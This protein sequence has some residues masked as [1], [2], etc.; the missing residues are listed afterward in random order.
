VE[1]VGPFEGG[2]LFQKMVTLQV[3]NA[4]IAFTSFVFAAVVTER[5]RAGLAVRRAA[6]EL[7]ERVRDRTSELSTAKEQ[8]RR[9]AALLA[10]AQQIAHIGSWEWDI[11]ADVV[12]WSDELFR[13]FGRPPR[14]FEATYDGY[15]RLIHPEDRHGAHA[16]VQRALRE[17][18]PFE[19]DYRVIRPDGEERTVRGRGAVIMDASGAPIR[20]VGTGQDI[21]DQRRAEDVLRRF[22]ANASHEL[23]T[24]LTTVSG[25][26]EAL[27]KRGRDLPPE[28]FD[29][30]LDTLG[31]QGERVRHLL[32]S[33]LDLSRAE[34]GHGVDHPEP[35]G[36]AEATRRVM[37][38]L[39]SPDGTSVDV[40][41]PEDM[42]VM[43]D[44]EALERVLINLLTNAYKYGG[45][46][47]RIEARRD[48]GRSRIVVADDGP[49]V[50]GETIPHLFEPFSR[51]AEAQGTGAGLGLAIA[52]GLVEALGGEIHYEPGVP[53]GARFV[54]TLPLEEA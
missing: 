17:R 29:E 5:R 16:V 12:T 21:T 36:L 40:R 24:P 49:G 2:T 46:H 47:I 7:E 33:L 26:A 39:S 43:V 13:I 19:V 44:S 53:V 22:I 41:V 20:M 34:Q 27:A 45:P 8:F 15:L 11:Q 9:T 3:F 25:Y 48:D 31:R 10:E 28:L 1:G 37:E 32:D 50:P 23:R 18:T 30:F 14:D 54:M 42:V 38:A 52:R 4:G 6:L 51:G 35:V